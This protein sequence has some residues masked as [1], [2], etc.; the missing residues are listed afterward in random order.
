[1]L[2]DPGWKEKIEW[3]HADAGIT[4]IPGLF[5]IFPLYLT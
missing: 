5:L 2:V 1:M 4:F 3:S